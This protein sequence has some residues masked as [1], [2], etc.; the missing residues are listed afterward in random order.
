MKFSW[1]H[2]LCYYTSCHL[3]GPIKLMGPSIYRLPMPD[4]RWFLQRYLFKK[5]RTEIKEMQNKPI[6]HPAVHRSSTMNA[7]WH[8]FSSNRCCHSVSSWW[9]QHCKYSK[10]KMNIR[11]YKMYLKKKKKKKSSPVC[12]WRLYVHAYPQPHFL[13]SHK[14]C[15]SY[16]ITYWFLKYPFEA[17]QKPDK[18]WC[19][20][21]K[22]LIMTKPMNK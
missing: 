4:P 22:C 6:K 10:V 21:Q 8:S 15:V 9:F 3:D 13:L 1:K 17:V 18:K 12:L 19:T 14:K 2:D 20:L 5:N 7:E 11:Y 16:D